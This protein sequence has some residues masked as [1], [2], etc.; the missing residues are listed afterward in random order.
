MTPIKSLLVIITV[1]VFALAGCGSAPTQSLKAGTARTQAAEAPASALML[2]EASRSLEQLAGHTIQVVAL[3]PL[4][5][6]RYTINMDGSLAFLR[7]ETGALLPVR[8]HKAL[9][10]ACA[11]NLT[12]VVRSAFVTG[13]VVKRIGTTDKRPSYALEIR[14]FQVTTGYPAR[15]LVRRDVIEVLEAAEPKGPDSGIE[16]RMIETLA[17]VGNL[18]TFKAR[19]VS[20]TIAGAREE[21]V[22]GTYDASQRS[23][24][25]LT[26]SPVR[27]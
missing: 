16:V 22:L 26:R 11:D 8:N 23:L 9:A 13:T 18:Y 3:N 12:E 17:G 21:I 6:N 4:I 19:V 10:A 24:G 20:T 25:Q 15:I 27:R 1:A 7:D 5:E 14:D 2:V